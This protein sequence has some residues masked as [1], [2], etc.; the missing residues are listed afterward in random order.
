MLSDLSIELARLGLS[1]STEPGTCAWMA[2]GFDERASV[3]SAG[4]LVKIVSSFCVLGSKVD[5]EDDAL[6][7]LQHR[8]A[9]VWG[10]F[11][12]LKEQLQ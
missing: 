6:L 8:T 9:L 11:W 4:N 10:Q 5:I 7:T 2:I 3:Y 12:K 1:L